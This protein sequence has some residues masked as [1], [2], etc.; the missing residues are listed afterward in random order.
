LATKSTIANA[1][2]ASGAAIDFSKLNI[3]RAD[4]SGLGIQDGLTAGS[5]ISLSSGTISV[6]GLTTSNLAS[7]AAITNA[8]LANSSTTLGSTTMTL[9]GTVTSVTG[10]V[11]VTSTGFTGALTGNAS[12][13]TK[14]AAT[15]NINGIAFDGSADITIAAN[16]NTLTGTT[17][18]SNVVTSSLS[19]VA[20]ITSGVWNG[21]TIAVAYGGTGSTT[22]NFV[23][24]TTDQ[25][26]AGAKTLSSDLTVN[27]IK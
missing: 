26:V 2:V 5:G 13:A 1:D 11:S 15:K 8:Q 18:A 17:L 10:L 9:G 14:L 3:T 7:N 25:T 4:I 24:L 6:T 22:K 20:T 23:D 19:S 16:A 27:G 12:T 21:S